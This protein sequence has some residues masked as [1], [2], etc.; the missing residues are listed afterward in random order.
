MFSSASRKSLAVF[1]VPTMAERTVVA[2]FAGNVAGRSPQ[3]SRSIYSI[4][5]SSD[6]DFRQDGMRNGVLHTRRTLK[7]PFCTHKN[8]K[9]SVNAYAELLS[10]VDRMG[11][12]RRRWQAQCRAY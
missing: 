6:T 3:S 5:P 8:K 1:L 10:E 9:E 11:E 2:S 7:I 4:F 12:S